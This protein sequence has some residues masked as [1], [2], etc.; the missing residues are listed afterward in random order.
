M[1]FDEGIPNILKAFE[2]D[3]KSFGD[4]AEQ[5]L[6]SK[7]KEGLIQFTCKVVDNNFLKEFNKNTGLQVKSTIS[8]M[9][10]MDETEKL[11]FAKVINSSKLVTFHSDLYSHVVLL[12]N[13]GNLPLLLE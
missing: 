9:K 7:V 4:Q 1:N 3:V 6:A 13:L 8:L 11:F 2:E 10:N 5:L 12:D